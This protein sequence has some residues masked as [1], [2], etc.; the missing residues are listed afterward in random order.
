[1]RELIAYL[2][3]KGNHYAAHQVLTTS[4]FISPPPHQLSGKAM[5][6]LRN[7]KGHDISALK[8]YLLSEFERQV[9]SLL[10]A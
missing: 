2:E 6:V 1:M 3:G 5:D 10:Q 7:R 9:R 8:E 4:T